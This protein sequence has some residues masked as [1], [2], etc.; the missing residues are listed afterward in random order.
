MSQL[1]MM[2]GFSMAPPM[3]TPMM[4]LPDGSGGGG[5]GVPPQH[6]LSPL[7][8]MGLQ[9]GM[10]PLVPPFLGPGPFCLDDDDD[11]TDTDED[12]GIK[13][14]AEEEQAPGE[15]SVPALSALAEAPLQPSG[16]AAGE[17]DADAVLVAAADSAE[18]LADAN[19][20]PAPSPA[21]AQG[22]DAA[23]GTFRLGPLAFHAKALVTA[24]Q[25]SKP[26]LE[27]V[28]ILREEKRC[29][30]RERGWGV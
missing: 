28:R 18:P 10:Q 17:A 14:E 21:P 2:G 6:A 4:P 3:R 22:A 12:E 8:N 29:A 19:G 27:A 26:A 15:E 1:A 30:G 23:K 5:F 24:E 25:D 11:E 7:A 20:K 16:A 13:D 9:L